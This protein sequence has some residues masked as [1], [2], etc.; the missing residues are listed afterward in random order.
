MSDRLKRT[1]VLLGMGGM[2]FTWALIPWGCHPFAE[3]QPYVNFVDSAGQYAVAVGVDAALAN[4]P[5]NLNTWMNDP[6]TNL[7]Q[8]I[9]S[10]FV[11]QTYP[12]DPT[13]ATLLR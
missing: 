9:W 12:E 4:V 13:Y 3:N 11:Q 10:G 6:V 2:A 8:S 5:Q 1:L 7:Y